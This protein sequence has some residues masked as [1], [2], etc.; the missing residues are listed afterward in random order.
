M[1]AIFYIAIVA[2]L[3]GTT[4][5]FAQ[6]QSQINHPESL[7]FPHPYFLGFPHHFLF[8]H[9]KIPAPKK[10][11]MPPLPPIV[12]DRIKCYEAMHDPDMKA[13]VGDFYAF[14]R[15]HKVYVSPDCCSALEK[16]EEAC[17]PVFKYQN[18][19]LKELVSKHCH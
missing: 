16:I 15:T 7:E 5:T 1:K 9:P 14:M 8:P 10:G 3:L 19:F 18:P 13:C 2:S 6:D 12:D 11:A 4:T 17:K